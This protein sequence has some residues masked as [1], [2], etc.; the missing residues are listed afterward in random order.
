MGKKIKSDTETEHINNIEV[1]QNLTPLVQ[2]QA[3]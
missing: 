3:Q 1:S 2:I